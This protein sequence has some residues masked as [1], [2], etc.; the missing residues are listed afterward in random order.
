MKSKQFLFYS[1]ISIW[2]T[3]VLKVLFFPPTEKERP[4]LIRIIEDDIAYT[5]LKGENV[6]DTLL[7]SKLRTENFKK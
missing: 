7:V 3:I 5:I 1:L 6:C 2:A 4:H